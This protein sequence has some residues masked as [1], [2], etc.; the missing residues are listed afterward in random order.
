[1]AFAYRDKYGI[2][3]VAGDRAIADEYAVGP[4]VE[5]E[6]S[7][8]DGYPVATTEIF[9]YGAGE[10]YVGGSRGNG[11]PLAALEATDLAAEVKE[12][13]AKIGL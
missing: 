7:E 13:L 2:L 12:I 4:V 1:M 6:V 8:R 9:D 5:A 11:K 10:V 3:H